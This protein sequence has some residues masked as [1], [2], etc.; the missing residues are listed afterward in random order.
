MIYRI[1]R[2]IKNLYTLSF[3][4]KQF[5]ININMKIET[6]VVTEPE[7]KIID[8]NDDDDDDGEDGEDGEG[9]PNAAK[10][11][12]SLLQELYVRRGLT[13]KYDL[14]QIEGQVHE[15]TFKYR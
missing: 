10:T 8:D 2:P 7:V 3:R 15:P 11:P 1:K 12:V 14:V 5:I 9:C 6:E 4:N 13:P